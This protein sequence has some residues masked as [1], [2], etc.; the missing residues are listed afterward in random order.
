MEQLK[1]QLAS[2]I[3]QTWQRLARYGDL[4][5]STLLLRNI[6]SEVR[7]RDHPETP[8]KCC[9]PSAP[10]EAK[11]KAERRRQ[12]RVAVQVL[13]QFSSKTNIVAGEG[14]LRDLSPSGCRITSPVRLPVGTSVECWMY[15]QN[16]EP[17]AVDEATVQWIGRREF[18]LMFK[19]VRV[20]VQRKIVDMCRTMGPL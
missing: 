11:S 6:S 10:F 14:K 18:G 16:G 3:S 19:T 9:G 2:L 5:D 7:E 15:P 8:D 1:P 20:G 4:L 13:S 17:F 12:D